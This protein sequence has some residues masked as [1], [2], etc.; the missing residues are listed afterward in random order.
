LL[1]HQVQPTL[2][3]KTL[4]NS[5]AM[6]PPSDTFTS[7]N[8]AVLKEDPQ[9]S[10]PSLSRTRK[11]EKTAARRVAFALSADGP[12]PEPQ[13][14]ATLRPKYVLGISS[15]HFSPVTSLLQL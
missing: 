7:H 6:S 15:L 12:E 11:L 4:T 8:F 5:P 13:V 3:A 2:P 9:L 14:G 1:S 10:I